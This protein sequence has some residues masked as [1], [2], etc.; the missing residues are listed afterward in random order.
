MKQPRRRIYT[1]HFQ[2][3]ARYVLL[4][5]L[6]QRIDHRAHLAREREKNGERD[7][8]TAKRSQK[9]TRKHDTGERGA[10]TPEPLPTPRPSTDTHKDGYTHLFDDAWDRRALEPDAGVPLAP[11]RHPH[12]PRELRVARVRMGQVAH[13]VLG[14][15]LVPPL[16]DDHVWF[17]VVCAGGGGDARDGVDQVGFRGQFFG[18]GAAPGAL[19][20]KKACVRQGEAGGGGGTYPAGERRVH[21]ARRVGVRFLA[22]G[23]FKGLRV[24]VA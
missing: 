6:F 14:R 20:V 4:E 19:W 24:R 22:F 17:G 8:T 15:L 11:Q 7:R 12:P 10:R 9:K 2:H 23:V 3:C 1:S 13:E 5:Q 16:G 21:L 18:A